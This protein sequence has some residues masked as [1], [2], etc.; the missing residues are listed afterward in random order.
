MEKFVRWVKPIFP[1]VKMNSDGSV[2]SNMAGMGGIIRNFKGDVLIAFAGPLHHCKVLFAE[3][4][5]LSYGL[6]LCYKMGF[7]NVAIEID[8][9]SLIH[10]IR[11]NTMSDPEFFYNIRKIKCLLDG[12]NFSLNHI[13]REGNACADFLATKGGQINSV[14][15]FS[16]I[17]L[18]QQLRGLVRLDK[19]GIPYIHSI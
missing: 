3:M 11:K 4:M 7:N 15:E 14:E 2:G 1:F 10:L 9:L 8:A 17:T 18:P 19:L 12:L 16:N 13:F 5:G 6:E